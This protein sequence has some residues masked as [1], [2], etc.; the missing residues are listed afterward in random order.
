MPFQPSNK[1]IYARF[2]DNYVQNWPATKDSLGGQKEWPG[3]EWGSG[4]LVYENLLVASGVLDWQRA[5]E[6]GP[7]SG[8]YT[9]RVLAGSRAVVRA[10]DISPQFLKVCEARCEHAVAEGRLSLH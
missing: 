7:G 2:W 6:I 3:D 1:S 8:K 5:V 10:Y 9:L 4:Q